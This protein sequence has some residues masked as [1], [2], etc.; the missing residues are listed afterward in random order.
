MTGSTVPASLAA[1]GWGWRPA[2]RERFAVRGLDLSVR[3]GERVL[4]LGP[5]GAGK[6]TLLAGLAGVLGG[7]D[8]GER[9]GRLLVDGADPVAA[10]GRVGL[11]LQNPESQIVQ[12]RIGDD[13]AFGNEN[14]GVPREENWLRVGEALDAVGLGGFPLGHSAQELS[15]GQQQRLALAGVL[16]MRP[17]ALLLD[18]PTA[19]LDPAGVTRIRDAVLAACAQT[20]STL[21]V[22]EHRVSVWA[23]AVDRVIVLDPGGGLLA[24]GVPAEVFA[25]HGAA[26]A[27]AGVWVPGHEPSTARTRPAVADPGA[28]PGPDRLRAEALS[29]GRRAATPALSDVDLAVRGGEILAITGENGAGKSTLGLTL[30]GLLPALSG[31][32]VS[33]APD[34]AGRTDPARWRSADLAARIGVVFQNPEHQFVAGTVREELAIGPRL[35]GRSEAEIAALVAQLAERLRLGHL[36][37]A[38]P[39][40]L[41]GGEQRRLSVA[42][43]L[44]VAPAV[45]ILDEPTFGQDALTW[46][47]LVRL[48]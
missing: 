23:D 38:N 42:T 2:G 6:S 1:E 3:A 33:D 22:V 34:R 43:A 7:D 17:G 30:A 21:L 14:L 29:V 48:L 39:F 10:R 44:G 15:G 20:G 13:V 16:A 26:L 27:A 12:A 47:E 45:L 36:L 11:V 32:V 35:A 18:E 25:R 46:A 28:N 31:R 9:E 24:D 4:L 19:N 5:S 40:T 37:Q 8:E 41:S